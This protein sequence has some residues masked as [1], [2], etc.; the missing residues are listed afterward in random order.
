MYVDQNPNF[1][2]VASY[3][4]QPP[5]FLGRYLSLFSVWVPLSLQ[6]ERR[7]LRIF[8]FLLASYPPI[9]SFFFSCFLPPACKTKRR[10][11]EKSIL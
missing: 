11:T 3:Q 10:A 6:S 4:G 7:S 9:S 8:S 1:P 2:H 5:Y